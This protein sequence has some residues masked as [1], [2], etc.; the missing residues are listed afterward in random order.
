[1]AGQ[2]RLLVMVA[3]AGLSTAFIVSLCVRKRRSARKV[4]RKQEMDLAV[5][6][7]TKGEKIPLQL[8]TEFQC[9][10][11]AVSSSGRNFSNTTKLALYGFYKQA[12]SGDCPPECR[13]GIESSMKWDAWHKLHGMSC[14]EAMR[15]YV[16]TLSETWPGWNQSGDSDDGEEYVSR[17]DAGTFGPSVSTMMSIADPSD[18]DFSQVGKLNE[19]VASGS[20]DLVLETLRA[21]PSLAFAQDK[22][23]MTPLHW[24]ADRGSSK[25]VEAL[26]NFDATHVNLRD[27]AGDTALHYAVNTGSR[28]V[29]ELLSAFG[30]D[31]HV[32]NEDGE[33]PFALAQADGWEAAFT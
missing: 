14:S 33:S 2:S 10:V 30:A 20:F 5:C 13:R 25:M 17:G 3:V 22:D 15:R 9:A 6:L 1:M 8:Q 19:L 11:S 32:T 7:A 23:G 21:N 24:A 16:E 18:V 31:A 26:L 4:N 12:L 27:S 29:A 28:D